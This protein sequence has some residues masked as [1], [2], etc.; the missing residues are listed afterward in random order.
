MD[1]QVPREA[2]MLEAAR[3]E[4]SDKSD[5]IIQLHAHYSRLDPRIRGDDEVFVLNSNAGRFLLPS[6][7]LFVIVFLCGLARD[8][9]FSEYP[10]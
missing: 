3:R 2:W 10:P 1:V 6:W 8:T 4:P 5:D 7:C 9:G